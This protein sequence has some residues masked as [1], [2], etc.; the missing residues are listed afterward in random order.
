MQRELLIAGL[1]CLLAGCSTLPGKADHGLDPPPGTEAVIQAEQLLSIVS[2]LNMVVAGTPTE[3]AEVLSAA[4]SDYD[5]ARTG[6]GALKYGLLL[7]APGHPGR[8]PAQAQQV[9]REAMAYPA[10]LSPPLRALGTVELQ[11]VATELS[12]TTEYQRLVAELQQDRDRPRNGPPNGTVTRQQYQAAQDQIAALRKE[13]DDA[14][15][16]LNALAEFERRQADRPPAT[17]RTNP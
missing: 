14:L 9:L 13:R 6:P 16:K 8:N 15:A 2:A 10:V 1:L 3:Q 17:E 5:H 11:R 4:A 7:A 12:L